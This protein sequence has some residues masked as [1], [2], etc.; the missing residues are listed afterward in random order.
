MKNGLTADAKSDANVPYL[1]LVRHGETS[2]VWAPIGP[3]GA[4]S[5]QRTTDKPERAGWGG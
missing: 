3:P 4:V 1:Q 5:D 2:S